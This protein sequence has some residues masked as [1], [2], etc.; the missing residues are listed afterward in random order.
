MTGLRETSLIRL[1]Y[2]SM[3]EGKRIP[4][5]IGRIPKVLLESLLLR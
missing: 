4:G 2:L 1:G 5:T 3:I